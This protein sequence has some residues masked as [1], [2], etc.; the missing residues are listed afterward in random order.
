KGGTPLNTV[1]FFFG[2]VA[3]VGAML[4][5]VFN[6]KINP[7][8]KKIWVLY[9]LMSALAMGFTLIITKTKLQGIEPDVIA[10]HQMFIVLVV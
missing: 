10:F 8:T 5:A 2:L 3:L 9:A 6:K 7:S 4:F 1:L